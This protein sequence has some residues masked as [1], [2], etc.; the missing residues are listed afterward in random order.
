MS[1]SDLKSLRE[2]VSA[3][4]SSKDNFDFGSGP[5]TASSRGKGDGRR[6]SSGS[7][8]PSI[9]PLP[10]SKDGGGRVIG[11]SR[12]PSRGDPEDAIEREERRDREKA[13]Y[14]KERKDFRKRQ[15]VVSSVGSPKLQHFSA[16]SS[17]C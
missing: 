7:S 12:G 10:P 1:A 3:W 14:K 16:S 6:H 13:Y 17:P 9:G 2:D 15:E 11:P 4:S 5:A 8:H